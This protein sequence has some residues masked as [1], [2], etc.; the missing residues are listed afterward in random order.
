MDVMPK[1]GI[2]LRIAVLSVHA[3]E[4]ALLVFASRGGAP[5]SPGWLV[6]H[7]DVTVEADAETFDAAAEVLTGVKRD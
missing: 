4:K 3:V 5:T 7:P 6:A 2:L 1:H